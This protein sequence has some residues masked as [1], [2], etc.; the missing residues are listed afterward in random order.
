MVAHLTHERQSP[1]LE[2]A[3]LT[4]PRGNQTV[5]DGLPQGRGRWIPRR[6]AAEA[7]RDARQHGHGI[8]GTPGPVAPAS[9]PESRGPFAAFVLFSAIGG[10]IGLLGSVSV[11]LLS[12][13]LL[14]FVLANALVTA[15][16]TVLATELLARFT[17]TAGRPTTWRGTFRCGLRLHLQSGGTAAVAFTTTTLAMCLLHAFASAPGPVVE[18]AVYLAASG[19]AGIADSCYCACTSSAPRAGG[20]PRP[21]LI[22][23]APRRARTNSRSRHDPFGR[24]RLRPGHPLVQLQGLRPVLGVG[25]HLGRPARGKS[26]RDAGAMNDSRASSHLRAASSL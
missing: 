17:F 8:N 21:S 23:P 11:G 25:H 15:V 26:P 22:C 4:K 16:S 10:G 12:A 14:P 18:Q 19:V 20:P 9:Q 2:I 1:M 5:V 6:S 13:G 24:C 3:G 7:A